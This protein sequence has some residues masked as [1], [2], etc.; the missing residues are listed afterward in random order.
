MLSDDLSAL[1]LTL[2]L[3]LCSSFLLLILVTP[4]AWWLVVSQNRFKVVV[5]ALVTLPMVLPPTVIGF[6]LLVFLGPKGWLGGLLEQTGIGHLAFSFPGMVIGAMFF[7]LPFVVQPLK[8]AF[9]GVGRRMLEVAAT[10]RVSPLEAFFTVVLP[11]SRRG[12]LSAAV[13]SFA[14]TLGEF[15][16]IL[17]IGGNIPGRTQVASIAIYEH[18]E[19]MDYASAHQLSAILVILSFVLL[20]VLFL[21]ERRF[22]STG[23][24]QHVF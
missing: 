22:G 15:G 8:N 21:T 2:Q 19:A 1:W 11:L 4:L 13:L 17:M 14:H 6:Y 16:V 12:F 10:L 3:A 5:E 7:S 23:G 20:L 24:K 18:V 9:A